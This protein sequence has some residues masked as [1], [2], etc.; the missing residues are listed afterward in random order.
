[1][2]ALSNRKYRKGKGEKKREKSIVCSGV[3]KAKS[4]GRPEK[5]PPIAVTLNQKFRLLSSDE[6]FSS[7]PISSQVSPF[8]EKKV[9]HVP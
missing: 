7:S 5:D 8:G 9:L 2:V 1:M 3:E 6:I 4:S